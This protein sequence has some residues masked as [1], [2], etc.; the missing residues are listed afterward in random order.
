MSG[1]F[2]NG[3]NLDDIFDPYVQGDKP[4]GTGY[5]TGGQDFRDRYAPIEYGQQ[6]ALTGYTVG[7]LDLN[8]IFAAAGTASY[9]TPQWAG[10][11]NFVI[12]VNTS[13]TGGCSAQVE[14]YLYSNGGYN[15]FPT[16]VATS[17][18]GQSSDSQAGNWIL[19]PDP[20]I[21]AE[22][23]A[24]VTLTDIAPPTGSV[25]TQNQMSTWVSLSTTRR[26]LL[27]VEVPTGVNETRRRYVTA[28]VEFRKAGQ[29][30]V[31]S[32]STMTIEVFAQRNF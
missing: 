5:S 13:S 2:V 18:L 3:V 17:G 12:S 8:S 9:V 7:G 6:A 29:T 31:I 14:F 1:Y 27:S 21:G 28:L 19:N 20:S 30:N 32:S 25:T 16:G 10:T 24:R 22:Y 26:V 4:S 11:E 23:E 15:I